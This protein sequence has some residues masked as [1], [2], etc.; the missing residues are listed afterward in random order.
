MGW[1]GPGISILRAL[2]AL[3]HKLQWGFPTYTYLLYAYTHIQ[4]TY[5]LAAKL[6]PVTKPNAVGVYK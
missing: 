3:H 4:F 6:S 2:H 5:P 1:A